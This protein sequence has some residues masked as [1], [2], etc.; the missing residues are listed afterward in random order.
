MKGFPLLIGLCL[1]QVPRIAGAGAPELEGLIDSALV[2]N[3]GLKVLEHRLAAFEAR[4][5]RAGALE[6]PMLRLDLINLP[7]NGLDFDSTPMSGKQLTI[8]QRIPLP[9]L[10]RAKEQA[11]EYAAGAAREVLADREGVIVNLVKQG[12][13]ALAFLDRAI[14]VTEKNRVLLKD[15]IRIVRTKYMVGRGLQQDVLKAQVSLS[16]LDDRLIRLKT[17][18][19]LAQTRLNRVISRPLRTSVDTPDEVRPTPLN[20]TLKEIQ[21]EAVDHRPLLKE[22]DQSISRWAATEQAARREGWPQ[23]T[24]LLGYRQRAPVGSDPVKGSDFLSLGVGLNLPIF[25]GR[26]RDSRIA[27]SRA[28]MRMGQAQKEDASR[29]IQ[30]RVEEICLEIE[31]HWEEAELFRTAILPQA[32]QSLESAMA[33]YQVDKVDFLTL[34][35]NQVSLFNFEIEY[36]RHVIQREKKLA[37]LEAV[38]GKRLF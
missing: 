33:G 9:G 24:F 29:N 26:K 11:A 5:P 21:R 16:A 13:Y 36:Y 15:L 30:F 14:E 37:E 8:S 10:L 22:I 3:T 31:Q 35:N 25:N 18:R 20:L 2:N 6:D 23:F 38:V 28:N 19:R 7:T 17:G 4:V 32:Q 1:V 12:Y 34:L 27:E